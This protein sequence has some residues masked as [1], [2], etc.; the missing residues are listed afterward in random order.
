MS[1]VIPLPADTQSIVGYRFGQV[2]LQITSERLWVDGKEITLSPMAYRFL[3]GVCRASGALLTR[4][5]AFD[6]LWPGGGNGSDEALAQV[7]AKVRQAL[8]R[9]AGALITLRGRGFRIDLPIE[10]ISV[11]VADDGRDSTAAT[12][13]PYTAASEPP[14]S[15]PARSPERH[16]RGA[17]RP[18]LV[19]ALA[20]LIFAAVI[21]VAIAMRTSYAQNRVL[22]G[23]AI[24]PQEFGPIS[25]RGSRTLREILARDDDGDR[26]SAQHMLES[27]IDTEPQS[28]AAP[29]FLLYLIGNSPHRDNFAHWLQTFDER[30]PRDASPY[31]Q[32]LS[33]WVRL[34]EDQPGVELELLNAALKLEPSAWRLHLA[35]AH[36]NLRLSHFD[37]TLADLRAVPLPGLS[38]RYAMLIMSDRASLGD[39]DA[40][41]AQLPA[42]T[43]HAPLIADYVRARIEM[44]RGNWKAA[45]SLFETTSEHAE[46]EG[47][48][49]NF[50][51]AWLLGA[52]C[53]G[54]QGNWDSMTQDAERALQTGTEHASGRLLA[55]GEILLGY[56]RYR[57]GRNGESVAAWSRAATELEKNDATQQTARLTLLRTRIDPAWGVANPSSMVDRL[58]VTPGLTEL[59]AA[60]SAWLNCATDDAE[61]AL[62]AADAAGVDS[63]YFADE[64]DLLRQ[65]LGLPRRTT[66][67]APQVPYPMLAR[68]ISY[69]ESTR[70]AG[71]RSCAR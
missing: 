56:A 60:R 46:R 39:V 5:Q 28:A 58:S 31:L 49:G 62:A 57:Q 6:L 59:T 53:A 55:D 63:G 24:S 43:Q 19:A 65:D 20:L 41:Q 67:M 52:V 71:Q 18:T 70:I 27:L 44:A 64:A 16:G 40:M 35:R 34:Y 26:A 4:T 36:V 10:P 30:L 42:L 12:P 21:V 2:E 13:A 7:V 8:G 23:Y 48:Y 51:Y 37:R 45:Q 61:H 15:A 9:E 66:P 32:L 54:E 38:P 50:S 3:L 29:F 47:L 22:D 33:R 11:S 25:A 69:W 14:S 1:T 17:S 68:W